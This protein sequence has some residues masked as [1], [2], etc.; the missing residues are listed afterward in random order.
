MRLSSD[1]TCAYP[2]RDILVNGEILKE[3]NHYNYL[4]TVIRFDGRCLS[5]IRTRITT[6]K[7][8]FIMLKNVLTNKKMSIAVGKSFKMLYRTK[9]L[10]ACETWT[11]NRQ[12]ENH[13]MALEVWYL[14]KLQR[15]LWKDTETNETVHQEAD[16]NCTF[17]RKIRR[18]QSNISGHVMRRSKLD[19]LVTTVKFD[20][21]KAKQRPS[22]IYLDSLTAIHKSRLVP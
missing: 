13:L 12:A 2:Q 20:G 18:T 19:N 4:R 10:Y 17:I 22:G 15:I 8:A 5:E 14:K 7:V 16:E 21:E 11:V 6:A 9:L 3:I 1:S